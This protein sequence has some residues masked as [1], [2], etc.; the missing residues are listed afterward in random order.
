MV[1]NSIAYIVPIF[2]VI[3]VIRFITM[4]LDI[5]G[6]FSSFSN[7][8][9]PQTITLQIL[10]KDGIVQFF[11]LCFKYAFLKIQ[12]ILLHL[13]LHCSYLQPTGENFNVVI[14]GLA[15]FKNSSNYQYSGQ[16]LSLLEPLLSLSSLFLPTSHSSHLILHVSRSQCVVLMMSIP[17]R[18]IK[19]T[20][21][22][23]DAHLLHFQEKTSTRISHS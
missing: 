4:L 14:D 15:D 10:W 2:L 8:Q 13:K 18:E 3:Y 19:Q 6:Y 16:T 5:K 11:L 1:M 20:P 9:V 12:Q 21:L 7:N 17:S 23:G 22:L